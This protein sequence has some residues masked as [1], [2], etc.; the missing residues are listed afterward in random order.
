MAKMGGHELN[1][2]QIERFLQIRDDK[3]TYL[4]QGDTYFCSAAAFVSVFK[5][6][7]KN[8]FELFLDSLYKNGSYQICPGAICKIGDYDDDTEA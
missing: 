8:S 7:F 1:K 6:L 4:F 5:K 2:S 3:S